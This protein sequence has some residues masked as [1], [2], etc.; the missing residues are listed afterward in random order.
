[1][2]IIVEP[3]QQ[4]QLSCKASFTMVTRHYSP[5]KIIDAAIK[6]DEA[7]TTD[8]ASANTACTTGSAFCHVNWHAAS[9]FKKERENR[10]RIILPTFG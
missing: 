7:F 3:N 10:R 5:S 2:E 8:Q 9:A 1:M 6:F 4:K